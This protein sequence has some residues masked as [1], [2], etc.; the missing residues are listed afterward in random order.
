MDILFILSVFIFVFLYRLVKVFSLFICISN[1]PGPNDKVVRLIVEPT[2][3]NQGR[4][5]RKGNGGYDVGLQ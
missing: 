5:S 3:G 4:G 1:E 2:E